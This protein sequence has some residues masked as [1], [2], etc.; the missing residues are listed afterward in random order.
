MIGVATTGRLYIYTNPRPWENKGNYYKGRVT[1]GNDQETKWP[2]GQVKGS[3]DHL[4]VTIGGL[5]LRHVES[6]LR[7]LGH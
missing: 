3:L 6:G 2:S 7:D 1:M 5:G 4:I